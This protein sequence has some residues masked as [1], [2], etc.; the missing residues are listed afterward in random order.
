[1]LTNIPLDYLLNRL[2]KIENALKD[3]FISWSQV[4][5]LEEERI[6][7]LQELHNRGYKE[8]WKLNKREKGE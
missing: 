4:K 1:M 5:K 3:Y 2:D 6:K 8:H 7:I